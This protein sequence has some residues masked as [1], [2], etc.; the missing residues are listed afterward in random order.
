[1]LTAIATG[2]SLSEYL[3]QGAEF[4]DQLPIH[5]NIEGR[6]D[7]YADSWLVLCMFPAAMFVMLM[8][9]LVLPWLSP[10]QF[11]VESFRNTFDY[12]MMLVVAML[13]WM[14]VATVLGTLH[15]DPT[16]TSRWIFG[17]I[18]LFFVMM[19]NVLGKVRRNF[20]MGVR[21]PWT[22]ASETVWIQTHRLAAWLFVAAGLLGFIAILIGMPFYY[23]FSLILIAAVI[24][25]VYSLV[26]YKQLEKQGKL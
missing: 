19:G 8:L 5:W 9:N 1:V 3:L 14:H 2:F 25:A 21:T 22:L 13:G 12:I 20:W 24:P 15:H 16:M 4:P 6:A 7:G 11:Q 18:C 17:G 23:A 26:L 10:R